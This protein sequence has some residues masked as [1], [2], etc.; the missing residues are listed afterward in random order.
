MDRRRMRS[1]GIAAAVPRVKRALTCR[2]HSFHVCLMSSTLDPIQDAAQQLLAERDC[3]RDDLAG[4][5]RLVAEARE[6]LK[7]E[8]D[9]AQRQA[10][11]LQASLDMAQAESELQRA[12]AERVEAELQQ[13]K[14][15]AQQAKGT[16][17]QDKEEAQRAKAEAQRA[18]AEAQRAEEKRIMAQL[19]N[20]K[21]AKTQQPPSSPGPVPAPARASSSHVGIAASTMAPPHH[22]TRGGTPFRARH[23]EHHS[24]AQRFDQSTSGLPSTSHF[25]LPDNDDTPGV[26]PQPTNDPN[27]SSASP[28]LSQ[29]SDL[30]SQLARPADQR[31][32][33]GILRL[34]AIR[35]AAFTSAPK[36]TIEPISQ[37][38]TADA[39]NCAPQPSSRRSKKAH[40]LASQEFSAGAENSSL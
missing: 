8:R 21:D 17:Q 5:G 16:P 37:E 35:P 29:V 11:S 20:V 28:N 39:E 38:S 31:K 26:A 36:E 40:K 4:M 6:Q 33:T 30:V 32:P 9:E 3:L 2:G 10:K 7:K 15:T 24:P 18:K 34:S 25:A 1:A 12:K 13:A 14:D 27:K 23:D 19:K 22:G